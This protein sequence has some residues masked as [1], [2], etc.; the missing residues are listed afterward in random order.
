MNN[1]KR[2]L[3]KDNYKKIAKKLNIF[4]PPTLND[5][6]KIE[7]LKKEIDNS[8]LYLERNKNIKPNYDT[9]SNYE[10]FGVCE[11]LEYLPITKIINLK[12]ITLSNHDIKLLIKK[13]V[14]IL[15]SVK[16]LKLYNII[17]TN[18][19]ENFNENNFNLFSEYLNLINTEIN[20]AGFINDI[21]VKLYYIYI[22]IGNIFLEICS[23][24]IINTNFKIFFDILCEYTSIDFTDYEFGDC[25][26]I[27]CC[28][29]NNEIYLT[30]FKN[31]VNIELFNLKRRTALSY[32]FE[33]GNINL[34][35]ATYDILRGSS[36]LKQKDLDGNYF[37]YY[38]FFKYNIDNNKNIISTFINELS[39]SNKE[40]INLI[41]DIEKDN[42]SILLSEFINF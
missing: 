24:N 4:I 41:R 6:N 10:E 13:C 17:S 27:K 36:L 33:K 28:K 8:K 19:I 42:R 31:K 15:K 2:D 39:S 30:Y 40:L 25:A 35:N 23:S 38:F 3:N 22:I 18:L 26:L 16:K 7:Y 1:M 32:A 14:N 34:I 9:E 20:S 21:D 12:D 37:Y 11:L 29:N 5:E